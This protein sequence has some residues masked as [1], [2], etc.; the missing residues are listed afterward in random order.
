V[1]AAS[2]LFV[3]ACGGNYS[4]DQTQEEAISAVAQHAVEAWA[5]AGGNGLHD[6]L[7]VSAQS[8]CSGAHLDTAISSEPKPSAWKDT[9]DI[10]FPSS[11][12]ASATVVY[13]SNGQDVEQQWAFAQEDYSW[14]I[15]DL[16]GLS[17]C[18][19]A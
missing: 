18:K 13:V 9:K 4:K 12:S 16:P 10:K 3:A 8:H 1:V 11:I 7:S 19:S 15:S 6:Y 17:E 2:L 5:E 14:R